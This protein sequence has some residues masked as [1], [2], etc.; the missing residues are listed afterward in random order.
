[1]ISRKLDSLFLAQTL[2]LICELI[3]ATYLFNTLRPNR[4][5]ALTWVL[6]C[7][8]ALLGQ[9][10]KS[11]N[12]NPRL[13]NGWQVHDMNRPMPKV[14]QPGQYHVTAPSDAIILFDG[15][16]FDHWE[17]SNRKL[18]PDG[19]IP[20]KITDGF[21]EVAGKGSIRTRE[22]FGDIQLHLEWATPNPVTHE[23]AQRRGNSGIHLMGRYEI[24]IMDG[25]ENTAYPD[26]MMGAVYGQTPAM[27]NA[28]RTPGQW[29][30][31]D[32]IFTAPEFSNGQLITKG[33]VT[34]LHNGVLVQNNTEILGTTMHNKLPVVKPHGP[35]AP[36]SLQNH[37]EPVRFRN[38][39]VR[40]LDATNTQ[41]RQ[42]VESNTDQETLSQG[43]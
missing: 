23:V 9:E 26:G 11:K 42:Q 30:S 27:V 13:P 43:Q 12:L 41:S 1:M 34:V 37:G 14:I 3:M 18:S 19:K 5:F 28:S 22:K 7:P 20:W 15:S 6:L 35:E 24:Q 2:T 31:Y 4:L 16:G 33:R 39:W 8:M 21:M 17:A 40:R 36:L 25:F 38:I 32:I 29:Q 10:S